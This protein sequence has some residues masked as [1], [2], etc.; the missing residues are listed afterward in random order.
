[1]RRQQGAGGAAAGALWAGGASATLSR[2]A[3]PRA[4][5]ARRGAERPAALPAPSSP[6][7]GWGQDTGSSQRRPVPLQA[8]AG[9]DLP[10]KT[11]KGRLRPRGPRLPSVSGEASVPNHPGGPRGRLSALGWKDHTRPSVPQAPTLG[12]LRFHRLNHLCCAKPV[13]WGPPEKAWPA[14]QP[15]PH[16][17]LSAHPGCRA[18]A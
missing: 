8:G 9:R 1:M 2:R 6:A 13:P 4:C 7:S 17:E 18:Q 5:Q 15:P 11:E 12:K 16:A 10:R 3:L 14:A